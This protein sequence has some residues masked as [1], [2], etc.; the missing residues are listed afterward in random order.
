M[1]GA[2]SA[3]SS[4]FAA[5]WAFVCGTPRKAEPS[6][7]GLAA[8][9][10]SWSDVGRWL[11]LPNFLMFSTRRPRNLTAGTSSGLKSLTKGLFRGVGGLITSP[12][13]GAY[14]G[15][16][17]GFCSGLASGV[18]GAVT[19]PTAGAAV[20]GMQVARGLLN[21]AEAVVES[22]SGKDWDEDS[23]TWYSYD[24]PQ[25]A[26]RVLAWDEDEP[27]DGEAAALG[28]P[29]A[30]GS[31]GADGA[32]GRRARG[33]KP[34]SDLAY[35][36]TLGVAYDAT[37]DEIKKA[38]YKRALRLHPDKNPGDA[39]ATR[40]FQKASEAY[41]VLGDEALRERYDAHGQAAVDRNNFMDSKRFFAM[42]FGSERFETYIGTLV[43]ATA[44]S[45][46]G[47]FS[48]R[49]LQV[50][51]AKREVECAL[52]LCEMVAPFVEGRAEEW[53]REMAKEAQELAEVPFGECLL[54]V[55]A[56]VYTNQA[57]QFLGFWGPD[58]GVLGVD[59][60]KAAMR[61]T[62]LSL[63]NGTA[64]VG[65]ATRA[66]GAAF[67][68]FQEMKVGG[69]GG[70]EA[71]AAAAAGGAAAGMNPAHLK[72]AQASLPVFLEAMWHVSVVDIERTLGAVLHKVCRDHSVDEATRNKRAEAL[73]ELGAIFMKAS[74]SKGGSKDARARVE[75][76]VRLMAPPPGASTAGTSAGA[77][78]EQ[79]SA[80]V[81]TAGVA[82]ARAAAAKEDEANRKRVFTIAE[83]RKMKVS[84]LKKLMRARGVD[85]TMAN[86][87]EEFI[88]I[89][90]KLQTGA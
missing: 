16:I 44:L 77:A 29:A 9:R 18:L 19:L 54:Y 65:A 50:R 66:A 36:E 87:K 20:G 86:E 69:D 63:E 71:A 55:V 14:E 27:G 61:G 88:Q 1:A 90:L 3:N 10:A 22:A 13:Q 80:S 72:A 6:S 40:L 41:Q 67:K 35:Y 57:E 79:H 58:A 46:E 24:L 78:P 47:R 75:E 8:P 68:T 32:G 89:L 28:G 15:G 81:P 26:A 85:V 5:A 82:A 17:G 12:L 64:L 51:Q 60:Y 56:E 11:Q 62:A 74:S 83:L 38:F 31:V 37:T 21:S 76:I 84:E 45:M 7:S 4:T 59:G 70:A 49:R 25:E 2:S 33:K 30:G 42:L 48:M 52:R 34:P 39:E 73:R 23:R 53:R 43:L